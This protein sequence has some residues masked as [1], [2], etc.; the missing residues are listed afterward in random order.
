[1]AGGEGARGGNRSIGSRHLV[2]L[3]LG[4]VVL[5]CIFFTLG[6][7]MGR[8]QFEA[9]G[10]ASAPAKDSTGTPGWKVSS[11]APNGASKAPIGESNPNTGTSPR[12][13]ERGKTPAKIEEPATKTT[14]PGGTPPGKASGEKTPPGGKAAAFKPPLIPRGAIVLQIAALTKDQDALALAQALQDKGFPTFVLTPSGDN[15]YRVQVGPYADANSADMAKRA[16]EHEG[17]KAIVKR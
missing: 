11:P 9:S 16:L 7:V 13:E 15:Y 5:C 6:Y 8:A 1:M 3:F 2:G 10:R 17:F 14:P 4:I 12:V